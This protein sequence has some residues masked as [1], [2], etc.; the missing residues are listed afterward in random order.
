MAQ[1]V[2][3]TNQ[4][5]IIEPFNQ[6]FYKQY[7]KYYTHIYSLYIEHIQYSI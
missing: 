5:A 1:P 6:T 3:N 4:N 2:I 7:K